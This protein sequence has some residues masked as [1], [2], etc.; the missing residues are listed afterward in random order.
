MNPLRS[1]GNPRDLNTSEPYGNLTT[2][3]VQTDVSIEATDYYQYFLK[4][5]YL[6]LRCWRLRLQLYLNWRIHW[7][8]RLEPATEGCGSGGRL[9]ILLELSVGIG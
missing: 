4:W 3:G 7:E 6:F 9:N 1:V 5:G 8:H 2:Y